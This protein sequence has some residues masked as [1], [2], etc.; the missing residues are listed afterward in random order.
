M[1]ITLEEAQK[2]CKEVTQEDL[3]GIEQAI[4]ELTHNNFQNRNVRLCGYLKFD[5]NKIYYQGEAIGFVKGKTIQASNTKYNDGLYVISDVQHD[6]IEVEGDTS[7]ISSTVKDSM[8]TLVEY[9]ADILAGVRKL[10][11][12]DKQMGHKMGVK[13]ETI[14]R[15]SRS[16]VDVN[17][18]ESVNGYPAAYMGFLNK[19]RKMK[20]W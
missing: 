15:W 9:P 14:S 3:N 20:G 12:Y 1:I 2:V 19:Y 16:F 10:L 13:S 17:A 5:G 18:G 6:Y 8:I 4:R 7:F 11:K